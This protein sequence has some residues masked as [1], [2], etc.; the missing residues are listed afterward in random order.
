MVF[1]GHLSG[2]PDALMDYMCVQIEIKDGS[3]Q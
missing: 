1:G 3:E 2:A